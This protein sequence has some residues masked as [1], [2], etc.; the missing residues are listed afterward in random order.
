MGPQCSESE[1][2]SP[3]TALRGEFLEVVRPHRVVMSWGFAGSKDLPPGASR[4]EFTLTTTNMGTR[5]DLL[6]AHLPDTE[7]RGHAQGW[8][9]FLPRLIIAGSGDDPG[10]DDWE[11][12]TD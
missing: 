8:A 10:T 7:A 3:V 6:H 11:P 1:P 12:P 5:V 9:H 4:V 2:Q